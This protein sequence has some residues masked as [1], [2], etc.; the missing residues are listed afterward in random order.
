M[1]I[2]NNKRIN[3]ISTNL[4][5]LKY[6]KVSIFFFFKAFDLANFSNVFI[7][8]IDQETNKNKSK[9]SINNLYPPDT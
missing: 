6:V 4:K 2:L 1:I 9:I 7:A 3:K 8:R 5:R